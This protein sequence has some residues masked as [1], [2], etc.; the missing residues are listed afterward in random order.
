MELE[1]LDCGKLSY[2]KRAFGFI[3]SR[4]LHFLILILIFC[5]L[6]PYYYFSLTTLNFKLYSR[7]FFKQFVTSILMHRLK[8]QSVLIIIQYIFLA[9]RKPISLNISNWAI[10][11]GFFMVRVEKLTYLE[12][13]KTVDIIQ[14]SVCLFGN[15]RTTIAPIT[16]II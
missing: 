15:Q 1:F 7:V 2:F 8:L 10:C 16:G 11:L 6:I 13:N 3:I 4:Y 9:G 5:P 14:S 12:G